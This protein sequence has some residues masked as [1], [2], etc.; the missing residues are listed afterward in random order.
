[1]QQQ[2]PT[3]PAPAAPKSEFK[4]GQPLGN[5]VIARAQAGAAAAMEKINRVL[6]RVQ[7]MKQFGMHDA[8]CFQHD[9]DAAGIIQ[10]LCSSAKPNVCVLQDLLARGLLPP[11]KAKALGLSMPQAPEE[12]PE[13]G[14]DVVINNAPANVRYLLTKR[15]TQV[16][17]SA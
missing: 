16:G 7:A 12:L 5:D 8:W 17:C 11:T 4:P 2:Q 1:M 3:A 15:T 9:H 14:Q 10:S 13:F 6:F